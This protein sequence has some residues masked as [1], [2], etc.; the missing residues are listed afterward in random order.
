MDL[1]SHPES[2]FVTHHLEG[3]TQPYPFLNSIVVPRPIALITTLGANG[4]VNAAPFSYFNAVCANPVIL[5]IAISRRDGQQKDTARNIFAS[6][7]FVINI[8]SQH[9]AS[10]V[11]LAG[12]EFPPDVSEIDMANLSLIPSQKIS[13]PRIANTLIQMECRLYQSFEVTDQKINLILGEAVRIH[14][15]KDI[16]DSHGRIE[17]AKLNPLARLSGKTYATINDFFDAS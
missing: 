15:H 11:N 9:L 16:L 14:I 6:R 5:S 3:S 2:A 10:A 12:M 8:C 1:Q 13:V 7:E 4:I 17:I